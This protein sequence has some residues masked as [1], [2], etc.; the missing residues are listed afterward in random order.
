MGTPQGGV[1]SPQLANVYM[2]RCPEC[3]TVPA[4]A[5]AVE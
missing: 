3:G 2:H 1:I 5:P 4:A